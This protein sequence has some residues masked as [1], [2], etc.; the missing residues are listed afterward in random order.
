MIKLDDS[1]KNHVFSYLLTTYFAN[2]GVRYALI[3]PGSRNTP[4]T[5]ALVQ[6]KYIKTYSVVDERSSA[7]VAL[8]KTK[9][10]R[11]KC[12]VI[13]VTTS[14]SAVANLFPGVIESYMSEIPMII[15]TADRPKKL[16]GTGANQTIY[17]NKIFGRYAH[18]FDLSPHIKN[19]Q[20][21]LEKSFYFNNDEYEDKLW[22]FMCKIYAT[23]EYG[24]YDTS[25]GKYSPIPVHLNIPFDEPLYTEKKYD[26]S[27]PLSKAKIPYNPRIYGPGP[28]WG[29][30]HS[31]ILIICTD[32]CDSV[33]I[34]AS[35]KYNVPIFMEC[36]SSRFEKKSHNIISNY[37]FILRNYNVKP[38]IILRFGS[39]PI[40]KELNKLID[41]NKQRTYLVQGNDSRNNLTA[42]MGSD[43]LNDFLNL[44]KNINKSWFDDLIKMQEMVED[45]IQSFFKTPKSHEGYIINTIISTMPKN[46]NLMIGNSSPIR[47]LDA[48]TFNLDKKINIY[49]NR[50]ASGI[51]GL[52]STAIGM[53]INKKSF[54]TLIIGDVSFYY[55]LTALNI[56]KN[57]PVN[58]TIFIINNNGGHIFDRLDGLKTQSKSNYDKYWLTPVNLDVKSIAKAFD[59]NYQ[60]I[61]LN[62]YG[63]LNT[64]IKKLN[65]KDQKINL[66]EIIVDSDKHELNNKKLENKIKKL[67]I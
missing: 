21:Y 45:G 36:R 40:S 8:G 11:Y 54:N 46:S 37:D 13:V 2:L 6:N 63:K 58:L 22:K 5:Q 67:F 7:F 62:Q 47:D 59:C 24:P 35:E 33:I 44:N 48:F 15:I 17:Q 38:D 61:N 53:S 25:H 51:D 26:F 39:R 20:E 66:V 29:F 32:I 30:N 4:L 3:S 14:G 27:L 43:S 56:A 55:D 18:F 23:Y 42:W 65:T 31:R 52:I 1:E 49:S 34:K 50:G 9:S 41:T 19:I 64:I 12:P 16:I 60:K 57:I 10:D 28:D